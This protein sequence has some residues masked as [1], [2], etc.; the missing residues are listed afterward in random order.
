[1]AQDYVNELEESI[2]LGDGKHYAPQ[3][4][5]SNLKAIKSWADWNR[6]KIARKIKI[7]DETRTPT[8]EGH[9]ASRL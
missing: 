5:S 8:L 9:R 4:I 7:R 6:K 3:Y 2:T 1:M